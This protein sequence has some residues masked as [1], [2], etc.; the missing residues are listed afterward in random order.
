MDSSAGL[1]QWPTNT[2]D[3]HAG[4]I[5]NGLFNDGHVETLVVDEIDPRVPSQYEKWWKPQ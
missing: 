4:G 3:R 2:S 5:L 1:D